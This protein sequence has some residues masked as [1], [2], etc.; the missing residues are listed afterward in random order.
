MKNIYTIL[1]FFLIALLFPARFSGAQEASL[2]DTARID[3]VVV[4][5]TKTRVNRNNVPLT[6]SVVTGKQVE[7][8][9]ESALLPVLSENVPGL[10]VTERGIT[11]F[12][13]SAGAAGG[14]SRSDRR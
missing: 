8:S 5:G 9:S 7:E 1:S 3:E 12:G 14:T 11:G 2:R 6:V 10:F 4:T 13:V